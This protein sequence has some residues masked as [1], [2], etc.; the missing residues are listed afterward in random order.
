MLLRAPVREVRPTAPISL[1]VSSIRQDNGVTDWTATVDL[2]RKQILVVPAS[3][4]TVPGGRST[5]L[6]LIPA[7]RA[8][9]PV[10]VFAP[11]HPV[12]LPLERPATVPTRTDSGT[13]GVGRAARW[14]ADRPADRSGHCQRCDQR[15]TFR[16]QRF[17]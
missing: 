9:I 3:A 4:P 10:G 7:G 13:R 14:L 5:Q 16:R 15:R 17:E 1:L 2:D 6:W 11:D 12:V 8:P